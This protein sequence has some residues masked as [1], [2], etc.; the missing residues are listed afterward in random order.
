MRKDLDFNFNI[1]PLTGDLSTVKGSK[2]I[3]QSLNNIVMTN[4]YE[5]GYNLQLYTNVPR[6]LFDNLSNSIE[7]H[8]L[9]EQI[10]RSIETFEPQVELIDV[11]T[12]LGA[13]NDILIKIMYNEINNP[14]EQ[15]TIIQLR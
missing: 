6:A 15:E 7:L 9:K 12:Q 8:G 1:H 11:V 3:K 4:S 10:K 13:D 14:S 5:R 2:A